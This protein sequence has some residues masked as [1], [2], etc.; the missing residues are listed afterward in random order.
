MLTKCEILTC[1][2]VHFCKNYC[3]KQ[4]SVQGKSLILL[5]RNS[6]CAVAGS[7]SQGV[8]RR[9]CLIFP[10]IYHFQILVSSQNPLR[11]VPTQTGNPC[12]YHSQLLNF[13]QGH[14][15]CSKPQV[16]LLPHPIFPCG[17]IL[18]NLLLSYPPRHISTLPSHIHLQSQ[19]TYIQGTNPAHYQVS[20]KIH[21]TY[22]YPTSRLSLSYTSQLL[23][24]PSLFT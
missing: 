18:Y 17:Q 3:H 5:G 20:T 13:H 16:L 24:Q 2:F 23:H 15:A 21:S 10:F 12:L 19:A 4:H 11:S 14:P 6:N 9:V 8:A 1:H 7:H 22:P